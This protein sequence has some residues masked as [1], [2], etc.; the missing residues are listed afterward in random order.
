[1]RR[2]FGAI[3]SFLEHVDVA[4]PSDFEIAGRQAHKLAGSLGSYGSPEGS[5]AAKRIEVR[6]A[7]LPPIDAAALAA[8]VTELR[9]RLEELD[10]VL[11]AAAS[12]DPAA[13]LPD[14]PLFRVLIVD[15]DPTIAPL[16][17]AELAKVGGVVVP[18]LDPDQMRQRL[19][20]GPFDVILMDMDLGGVS[21]TTMCRELRDDP[22]TEG[23]PIIAITA[24]ASAERMAA[25]FES[26]ANDFVTKPFV[27]AELVTRIT[28]RRS[29][30]ASA[31]EFDLDVAIVED[32][33]AI[34]ALLEHILT[35]D[36]LSFRRFRDGD[37]A[38]D[39]VELKTRAKLVLLDVGLPG[40]DGFGV[41]RALSA[42]GVL[43]ATKVLMLTARSGEAEV[44][45][46]L[47]LGATD[48][49]EK[50]FSLAILSHRI[51]QLLE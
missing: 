20:G 27:P 15:D 40:V 39:L 10:G 30:T 22:R 24:S 26:G 47:E 43:E 3:Q 18:A 41:L 46:A 1:M 11:R 51:S 33:D 14:V 17:S 6:L 48:H 37:A 23:T 9:A 5:A 44:L 7:G 31:M 2:Q 21:G 29:Q 36:G 50:P 35:R 34:A 12:G 16:V 42:A 45:R 28:A 13:R 25:A 19:D 4:R 32:D 49:V 8:D 38:M